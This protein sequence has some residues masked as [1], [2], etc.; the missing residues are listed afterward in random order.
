MKRLR[1]SV[2]LQTLQPRS[3]FRYR[4]DGSS[5]LRLHKNG[6]SSSQNP[7]FQ[8]PVNKS[9]QVQGG[10]LPVLGRNVKR[11]KVHKRIA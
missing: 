7:C 1:A 10:H 5:L 3:I 4:V 8:N 6:E 2:S 11:R 9:Q